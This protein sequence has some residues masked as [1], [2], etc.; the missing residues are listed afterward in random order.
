MRATLPPQG[1]SQV[2]SCSTAQ[3]LAPGLA[4]GSLVL[5]W[6]DRGTAA[7]ITPNFAVS[8]GH[9]QES[10]GGLAGWLAGSTLAGLRG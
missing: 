4:A 2:C 7:P 3:H 1:L 9:Q 8:S 10:A 6:R 5:W